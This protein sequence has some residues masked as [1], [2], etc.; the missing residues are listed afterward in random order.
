MPVP[1]AQRN[2]RASAPSQ[3]LVCPAPP[4][5]F[6]CPGHG[7]ALALEPSVLWGMRSLGEGLGILCSLFLGDAHPQGWK[8]MLVLL[9]LGARAVE[10]CWDWG[11]PH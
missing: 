2:L 10:S 3:E 4:L 1:A 9:C 6:E 5:G 8:Q 7:P 11:W